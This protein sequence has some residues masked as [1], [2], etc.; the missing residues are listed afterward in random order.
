MM[1]RIHTAG[2]FRQALNYCLNDKLT[3]KDGE[4]QAIYKD[5]AEILQYNQCFGS[6]QE[7]IRQFNEVSRLNKNLSRPAFHISLSFPPGEQLTKSTLTDIASDCA[8][9][10]DFDQHQYVTILHKDTRQQHIHIVANRIGFD[11][12]VADDSY[13]YGHIADFCRQAERQHHL[14]QELGPRLYQTKEQRQMPRQGQRL[15]RLRECIRKTL[16][17]AKDYTQFQRLMEL[18][19]YTL[20]KDR[21]IVFRDEK[22]V[23]IKGSEAGYPLRSIQ[24]TLSENQRLAQL[25]A[26]RLAEN[27]R[28]AEAQRLAEVERLNQAQR[29]A[30]TEHL[31]ETERPRH[32]LS[33]HL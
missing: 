3:L 29:L 8:R 17:Q 23:F 6:R 33:H 22:N 10:L 26:Q 19:G 25:E 9:H 20:Y 16:E 1:G 24:S 5:R 12:H 13:S 31:A 30:E 15:D 7:L 14:K 18:R 11:K 21:G 4:R 28:L 32:R 27:Q 2:S